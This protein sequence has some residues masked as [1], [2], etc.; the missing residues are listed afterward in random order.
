MANIYQD[1]FKYRRDKLK[2]LENE[3]KRLKNEIKLLKEYPHIRGVV[4]IGTDPYYTERKDI[5]GN[6]VRL[7][8]FNNVHC[9]KN[10][11][12]IIGGNQYC[13]CKLAN[14]PY[15][16][17]D[18]LHAAPISNVV[19]GF[20]ADQNQLN[21]D[22]KAHVASETTK[23]ISISASHYI[24]GFMAGYGGATESNIVARDVNYKGRTLYA[25]IP[26][27]YTTQDRTT[28]ELM[29]Y[30][31]ICTINSSTGVSTKAYYIKS[32]DTPY[33][34]YHLWKDNGL[35]D[36]T[37]TTNSI[38][39]TIEDNG[40]DMESF[41]ECQLSINKYD[42]VDYFRQFIDGEPARVNEIGLIAAKWDDTYKEFLD[43][44]LIS[45]MCFPTFVLGTGIELLFNY[46][47]YF[48]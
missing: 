4:E 11:L 20:V 26:F 1:F 6:I 25:P 43:P 44:V 30:G 2:N 39:D 32:L 28:A 18:G 13:M 14:L 21:F 8:H 35:E 40:I 41:C 23:N 27:R 7:R 10:N 37:P 17:T 24:V 16:V 45:H 48:K 29:K 5:N 34:I 31:G 36:G 38:F 12:I 46:R 15:T 3:N 19:P 42:I 47:L 22:I 9:M 33:Q